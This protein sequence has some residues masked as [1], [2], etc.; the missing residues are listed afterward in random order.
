MTVEN[1]G[2]RTQCST[3][4]NTWRPACFWYETFCWWFHRIGTNWIWGWVMGRTK[5]SNYG[6]IFTTTWWQ[7]ISIDPTNVQTSICQETT[8][9]LLL[10]FLFYYTAGFRCGNASSYWRGQK[11]I[12]QSLNFRECKLFSTLFYLSLSLFHANLSLSCLSKKKFSSD[13]QIATP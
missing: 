2:S 11:C 3:V 9:W 12:I 1:S 6:K 4:D 5:L 8:L 7:Y 10:S 13:P